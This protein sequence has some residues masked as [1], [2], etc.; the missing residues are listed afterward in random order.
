[1]TS[2]LASIVIAGS[3]WF[4]MEGV[5]AGTYILLF[6]LGTNLLLTSI[7]SAVFIGMKINKTD[8]EE[9]Y[10]IDDKNL[11]V[12]FLV[13]LMLAVGVWHLF[14][15]GYVFLSGVF[16]VSISISILATIFRFFEKLSDGIQ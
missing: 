5:I 2:I 13:Q 1:M 3:I 7:A 11:N 15:V 9:Q 12:R 4:S 16:L 14:Q 8:L 6:I 10:A